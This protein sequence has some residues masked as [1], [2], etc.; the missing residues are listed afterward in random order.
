MLYN[1]PTAQQRDTYHNGACRQAYE[2]FGAHPCVENDVHM[3]HF[4]L[5]A[6]NAKHVALVGS[7]NGWDRT[8]NPMQKQFDGT[9]ELRITETDVWI[10]A[11]WD[12]APTYKYA[13][14]GQDDVWRL[15]ADPYGFRSELRPNTASRLYDLRD[16]AWDDA[17]WIVRRQRFNP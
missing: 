5:W 12:G 7:F 1:A 13:V 15:K 10:D 2:M 9:W 17:A 8:R 6:P 11:P 14:W 16:Y 3:W 4:S